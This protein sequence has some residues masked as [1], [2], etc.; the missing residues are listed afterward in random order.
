MSQWR[1]TM[2]ADMQENVSDHCFHRGRASHRSFSFGGVTYVAADK[3][4]EGQAQPF[5]SATRDN[6]SETTLNSEGRWPTSK[7]QRRRDCLQEISRATAFIMPLPDSARASE[8]AAV[9][10]PRTATL[11]CTKRSPQVHNAKRSVDNSQND[12]K[13]VSFGTTFKWRASLP[14]QTTE[15]YSTT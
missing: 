11:S 3:A 5:G 10:S 9:L 13:D 15:K 6:A 14:T 12:W 1:Y 7:A 2:H 8:R 4:A